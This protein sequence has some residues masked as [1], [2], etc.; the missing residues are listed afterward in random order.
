MGTQMGELTKDDI[1][2]AVR[3]ALAEKVEMTFGVDCRSPEERMET[4]KDME[5][6]RSRRLED[7]DHGDELALD[8]KFL[9]D[10]RKGVRKGGE[11]IFWWVVGIVGMSAL[12]VFWPEITRRIGR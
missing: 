3:E 2:D 6:L 9:R 8:M 10:L 12:A 5:F 7:L 11:K 4:R 1:K